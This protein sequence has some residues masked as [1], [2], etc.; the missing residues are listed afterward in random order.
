MRHTLLYSTQCPNCTRFMDALSRTPVASQVS[1]VDVATLTPQQLARV[2]AVP[3]LVLPNGGTLYGTKA[4]EWLK[5]YEG[6]VELDGFSGENGAL[7][8][9]DI[10][11]SGYACYAQNYSAFEPVKD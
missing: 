11:T 2:S 1:Y 10:S 7:A 3:A 9:S 6:E 4:F 5:Q 8:F